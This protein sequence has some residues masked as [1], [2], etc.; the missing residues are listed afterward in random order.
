MTPTMSSLRQT[1]HV[2]LQTALFAF[3]YPAILKEQS[4]WQVQ[5]P[6]FAFSVQGIKMKEKIIKKKCRV[7]IFERLIKYSDSQL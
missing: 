6:S 3:T 7:Y 5:H 1:V 2:T 4:T